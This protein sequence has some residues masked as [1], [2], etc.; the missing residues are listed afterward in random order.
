MHR[1]EGTHN[2]SGLFTD[3]PP[4]TTVP[5]A[6]FNAVQEE[7]AG[8]IEAAGLSLYGAGNDQRN[9]LYEA[10]C[11]TI[12]TNAPE[13]AH[14]IGTVYIQPATEASNTVATALPSSQA[15]ASLFGGTWDLLWEDEVIALMTEGDYNA[16]ELQNAGRTNGLQTDQMQR[17]QGSFAIRCGDSLDVILSA[18]GVFSEADG[19]S[20][21]T[22]QMSGTTKNRH[23]VS[24]DSNGSTSYNGART[25][26]ATRPKNRLMRIWERTS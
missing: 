24:F 1:T 25:G 18:S 21:V 14:P 10:I 13:D 12:R 26:Y 7:I 5:A 3:G 17:I 16:S 23:T 2:A 19:G 9:Q 6:W 15:P 4:A 11:E 8:V 22:A 20:A